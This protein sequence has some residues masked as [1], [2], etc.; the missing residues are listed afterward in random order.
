MKIVGDV[1]QDQRALLER[2]VTKKWGPVGQCFVPYKEV[3]PLYDAGLAVPDDV[4]LVWV[5]DNFGYI[6]RLSSAQERK[7]PGGA[8]VYWHLS[9]YGNPHSY[10]WINTTAPALMYEE[11]EKAWDNDARALWIINVGDIKPAEIG[12]DFFSKLA[13]TPQAAGPDVQSRF[14]RA[15]AAQQFGEEHAGR[16]ADLLNNFYRLGTVRK[17]ELMNR[18]WAVDLLKDVAAELR[19]DYRSLLDQ[20]ERLAASI[21]ADCRDAYFEMIGFPAQVLG[22]SGLI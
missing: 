2:Y 17:P 1:I 13:W 12:I 10:T 4:T 15:F 9:Y 5:D 14:L 20:D 16:I 21:P 11:L 18:S 19:R 6:R 3:L 7:R 8:G 22:N